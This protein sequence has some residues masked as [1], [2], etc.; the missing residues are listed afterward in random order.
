MGKSKE[1]SDEVT[2]ASKKIPYF[3]IK[4]DRLTNTAEV[5]R[6][7]DKVRVLVSWND[8]DDFL[9]MAAISVGVP[10][11]QIYEPTTVVDRRNGWICADFN[12]LNQGLTY[13]LSNLQ[14]WNQ[15]LVYNVK[16]LNQFSEENLM[17][18]WQKI[19]GDEEL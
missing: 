15:A 7:L 8:G 9:E 13:F 17:K 12:E 4:K 3:S 1:D 5:M 18:E 14:N 6:A 11:M 16:I 19:F 10:Q 2:L